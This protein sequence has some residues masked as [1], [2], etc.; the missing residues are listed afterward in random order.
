MGWSHMI[1]HTGGVL[2]S[3]FFSPGANIDE[4][5]GIGIGMLL[6]MILHCY[7]NRKEPEEMLVCLCSGSFPFLAIIFR[8]LL[9]SEE[10]KAPQGFSWEGRTQYTRLSSSIM[11]V[12][13]C[14]GEQRPV[15]SELQRTHE[16]SPGY[17]LESAPWLVDT[18]ACPSGTSGRFEVAQVRD[19]CRGYD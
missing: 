6:K 17:A 1:M 13:T 7:D 8:W 18:L 9:R 2:R 4:R 10:A 3:C 5:G 14:V 12:A 15:S 16:E 19:Y 11:L